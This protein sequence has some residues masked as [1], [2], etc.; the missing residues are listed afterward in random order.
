MRRINRNLVKQQLSIK[1]YSNM[2][3]IDFYD[4]LKP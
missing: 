1:N 4:A 2:L 3:Q